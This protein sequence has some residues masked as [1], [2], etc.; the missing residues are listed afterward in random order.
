MLTQAL[1]QLTAERRAGVLVRGATAAVRDP[2]DLG[3]QSVGLYAHQPIIDG[4]AALPH[5]ARRDALDRR[6]APERYADRRA[7]TPL[8]PLP[9]PAGRPACG[10]SLAGNGRIQALNCA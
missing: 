8:R 7:H 1:A 10:F 9:Q 5:Q 6:A 2:Y 3:V 4:L